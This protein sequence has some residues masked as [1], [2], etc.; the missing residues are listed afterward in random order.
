MLLL[1]L[2]LWVALLDLRIPAELSTVTR[3]RFR[4]DRGGVKRESGRR[5]EGLIGG[6]RESVL[7]VLCRLLLSLLWRVWSVLN[8]GRL[9]LSVNER[10]RRGEEHD[11]SEK[12][13]RW[14][15]VKLRTRVG[16]S[17]RR[18]LRWSGRKRGSVLV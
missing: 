6:G 4:S 14:K 3:S 2:M 8:E 17:V 12:L 13:S 1:L 5:C 18:R 7:A 9:L 16:R 10:K 11:G 15:R